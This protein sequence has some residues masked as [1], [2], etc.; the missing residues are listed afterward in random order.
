MIKTKVLSV[1]G[2]KGAKK[3]MCTGD[4]RNDKGGERRFVLV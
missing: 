3:N 2:M 4:E 1:V